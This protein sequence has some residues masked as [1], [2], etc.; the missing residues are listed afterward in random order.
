MSEEKESGVSRMLKDKGAR[1]FGLF[2]VIIMAGVGIFFLMGDDEQVVENSSVAQAPNL[3]SI[4]G[5]K[6]V[7]QAYK[8]GIQKTDANRRDEA[9][10]K[11][12]SAIPTLLP[13]TED[14]KLPSSLSEPNIEIP[15]K[16]DPKPEPPK[17]ENRPVLPTG[18]R[19]APVGPIVDREI[20]KAMQD[21]M[22]SLMAGSLPAPVDTQYFYNPQEDASGGGQTAAG[23]QN[24]APVASAYDY[25]NPA[26]KFNA[27]V[28]G[29][30]L[31]AHMLGRVNSDV[32]GP[33]VA[34][35]LQGEFSGARLLG[36]F[37]TTREGVVITFRSM[38]V[39][40]DDY[41]VEKSEVVPINAVAVD[42]QYL[43]S[44][45][46][47]DIDRHLFEKVAIGFASS[48]I[49]GLGEA[50]GNS[51]TT[52]V[53]L[54]DGSTISETSELSAKEKMYVAGGDAAETT[55]DILQEEFGNRP[56]TIT[57]EA[58]TP[59]GLLFVGN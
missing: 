55:G 21:Y 56:T 14:V 40:Y 57:V 33:V 41:G 34:E 5:S 37:S 42:S 58:G 15:K 20:Q 39:T 32:P 30:I 28:T 29:T 7:S 11:G 2:F 51:G 23:V 3:S 12:G 36:T 25:G 8:E 52:T 38:T 24:A 43:G 46:A 45:L 22:R 1:R 48:F 47:T 59:F 4:P 27:P 16:P 31:Y 6:P 44:A 53:V 19:P 18:T 54:T 26:R 9:R 35:I 50:I 13:N 17:V 10:E 49:K